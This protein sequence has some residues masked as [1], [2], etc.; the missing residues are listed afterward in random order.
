MPI[1]DRL[2]ASGPPGCADRRHHASVAQGT[3][4]AMR[5]SCS[6]QSSPA[7][8][9]TWEFGRHHREWGTRRR[10]RGF[11][12]RCRSAHGCCRAVERGNRDGA[13]RRDDLVFSASGMP[14]STCRPPAHGVA[15]LVGQREFGAEAGQQD[16]A[17]DLHAV[18]RHRG[19]RAEAGGDAVAHVVDVASRRGLLRQRAISGATSPA[20]A[21]CVPGAT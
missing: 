21:A 18:D 1:A 4:G 16:A 14:P 13:H 8:F 2:G 12:W 11:A 17:R 10:S 15:R 19:A 5:S 7:H 6:R 9:W 3:G 20:A